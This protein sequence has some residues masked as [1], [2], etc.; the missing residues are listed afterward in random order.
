[1]A[2]PPRDVLKKGVRQVE[3]DAD[4]LKRNVWQVV[5]DVLPKDAAQ[6]PDT[7]DMELTDVKDRVAQFDRQV[8]QVYLVVRP[9]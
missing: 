2:Q 8:R 1:M 5:R 6:D 3:K 7:F 4:G 9:V